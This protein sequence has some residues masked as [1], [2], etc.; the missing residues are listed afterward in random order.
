ML[1]RVADQPGVLG[2]IALVFT[3]HQVSIESVVQ[4]GRGDEAQLV[5][6]ARRR[7]RALQACVR[8]LAIIDTVARSAR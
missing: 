2:A 1:L 7:E 5:P 8:D 4:D 3:D 6:I